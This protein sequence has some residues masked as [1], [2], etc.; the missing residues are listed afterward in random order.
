MIFLEP[1]QY[2]A[3]ADEVF[4]ILQEKIKAKLP[5]A[6]IEHIGSSAIKGA[7]SKGDLDLFVGVETKDFPAAL[8]TL[9]SMG[10]SPKEETLRTEELCMLE[11]FDFD[12]D[13]AVQLVDKSSIYVFFLLFRDFL[14]RN[15]DFVER[16]NDLKRESAGMDQEKY[17]EKKSEFIEE[18]LTKARKLPE[19]ETER[20]FLRGVEASDI[21]TYQRNFADYEVIQHLSHKVPWPFPENGVRDFLEAVIWP[22]QGINRWAWALFEK[23]KRDEVIGIVDLWREGCPENRGFWLAKK[24]WGKGFMTEAVNPVMDYAFN[25]LGFEKLVF[26]N[27]VGNVRSRRV[28]EKTG[29]RFLEVR[30]AKF[31]SPQYTEQEVWELKKEDWKGS[32]KRK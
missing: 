24:H 25:E 21:P 13:V 7:V 2:Q 27:A 29:A 12:F 5:R 10:F 14:R 31:V 23:E 32:G 9:K 6:Q 18:V 8:E 22:K 16:Y 3:R 26:S 28:K 15:A 17:R 1:H 4:G 19:F 11:C 30:P 20:L